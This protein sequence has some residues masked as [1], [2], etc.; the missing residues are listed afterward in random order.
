MTA[1]ATAPGKSWGIEVKAPGGGDYE[2]LGT[3]TWTAVVV[4]VLDIGEQPDKDKDGNACTRRKIVIIF[5]TL[6]RQKNGKPFYLVVQCNAYMSSSS[7]LYEVVS[8]ITGTKLPEGATF[9][10]EMI[11]G[12]PC[13]VG[14]VHQAVKSGKAAGK[15]FHRLDNV[16]G[17][18]SEDD[19]GNP[20]PV[21]QPTVEL[22]CWS[23]T[24]GI[25]PPSCDWFPRLYGQTIQSLIESSVEGQS[26]KFPLPSGGKAETQVSGNAEDDE[27]PY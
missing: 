6:K 3:G 8:S 24:Q 2:L 25:A 7:H 17:W 27:V 23:V 14:I 15:T 1:T 21:P 5:E 11:L 16:A 12:K 13:A 4:G 19:N 20:K 26:G 22:V 9:F 18:S 10:P